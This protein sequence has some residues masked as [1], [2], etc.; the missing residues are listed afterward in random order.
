M[1]TL[2]SSR[3]CPCVSCP[4]FA[5]CTSVRPP[6]SAVRIRTSHKNWRY[7]RKKNPASRMISVRTAPGFKIDT[8]TLLL[9]LPG[10]EEEE[11]EEED[12]VTWRAS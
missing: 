11:E 3:Y 4:P 7:N 10:W 1:P 9:P 12:S 8:T 6:S 5:A 2:Q